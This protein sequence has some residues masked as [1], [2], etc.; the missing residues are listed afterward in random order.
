MIFIVLE[1]KMHLKN[2]YRKNE[3]GFAILL[4]RCKCQQSILH[5]NNV[6]DKTLSAPAFT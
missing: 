4:K 1:F 2:K 3:I 5:E 6:Y